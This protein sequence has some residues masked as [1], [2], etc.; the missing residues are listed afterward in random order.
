MLRND[1]LLTLGVLPEA[2]AKGTS[3]GAGAL[4]L[5]SDDGLGTGAVSLNG[6]FP[7]EGE[8]RADFVGFGGWSRGYWCSESVL[9]VDGRVEDVAEEHEDTCDSPEE[10]LLSA[11]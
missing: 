2:I 3:R 1:Q 5:R 10:W 9:V 7:G 4:D 11:S 6:R 8:R